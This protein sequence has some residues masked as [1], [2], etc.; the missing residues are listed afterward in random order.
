MN[1]TEDDINFE[2]ITAN[3]FEEVIFDLLL[4]LGFRNLVWRQGGADSGRDVEGIYN[5]VNPLIEPYSEKWFFE[6]KLY[7]EGVP[8][9]KLNSKIAWADAEKPK[10]LVFFVS[11]YLTN[12]AHTWLE[13]ISPDKY[14]KIHIIES[15]YIKNLLLGFPEIVSRYFFDDY[16]KLLTDAKK[17]WLIHNLLPDPNF[18]LILSSKLNLSRTTVDDL[19]FLWNSFFRKCDTINEWCTDNEPFSFDFLFL[20]LASLSN[21][22]KRILTPKDDIDA[23]WSELATCDWAVVYRDYLAAEIVLNKNTKPILALYTF[24]K[25]NE[26]NGIEILIAAQSNYPTKIRYIKEK[27]SEERKWL[28]KNVFV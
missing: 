19:A 25:D 3:Q 21:T 6:C 16:I 10:H 15:K 12:N 26:G 8:P 7:T 27:A 23:L 17:N 22:K 14:Y 18:Y 9:E 11:S 24:V 2:K 4:R 1:Y 13:K 20:H 28:F 5:T